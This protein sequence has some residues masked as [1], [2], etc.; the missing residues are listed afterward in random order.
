MAF[1][2]TT[3]T[4]KQGE[5]TAVATSRPMY[6]NETQRTAIAVTDLL[7]ADHWG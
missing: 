3:H 2:I 4:L 6:E 7:S 1:W 5:Q